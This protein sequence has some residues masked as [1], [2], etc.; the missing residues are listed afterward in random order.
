MGENSSQKQIWEALEC[1]WHLKKWV[2]SP[3][4]TVQRRTEVSELSPEEVQ[5]QSERGDGVSKDEGERVVR[6]AGEKFA[7]G[8]VTK[9]IVKGEGK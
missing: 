6:E 9:T 3:R 4:V 8:V 1:R 5:Y 7:V 2:R